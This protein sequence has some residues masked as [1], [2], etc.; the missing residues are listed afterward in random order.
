MIVLDASA[1]VEVLLQRPS[2]AEIAAALQGDEVKVPAHFDAEIFAAVRRL[3]RRGLIDIGRAELALADGV[4]LSAER[5]ALAPLV[6]EAFALRDRFGASDVFYAV[7][8]RD[9]A[10]TLITSDAA[11]ARA[12]TG[13]VEVRY[14]SAG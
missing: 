8:A 12:A 6:A 3:V 2:A 4:R 7:L 5:V 1:G 10:A 13:Y 14:I 9:R 11:L